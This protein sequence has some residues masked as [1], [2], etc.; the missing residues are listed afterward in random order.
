MHPSAFE[1]AR[2]FVEAYVVAG[3]DT[4]VEIGSQTVGGAGQRPIRPL[5]AGK[6]L[7][8][9]GVD[10]VAGEGV[11]VVLADPYSFPMPDDSADIVLSSSCFEHAQFFWLTF[12]E[13]VRICRPG[14]LL[15][16]SAPSNGGFHRYPVDCWRFYPDSGVALQD[17]ALRN[18]SRVTLLESYISKQMA[19][20]WNDFVAVWGKGE[21]AV[22]LHPSRILSGFQ[23][24]VNGRTAEN[25]EILNYVEMSE[26]MA[27]RQIAVQVCS[28][29]IGV[30]W[31]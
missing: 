1:S 15:Y 4:V 21:R 28:G 31:K 29:A 25:G 27:R 24:Y 20:G 10:F 6:A 2:R 7:N 3:V 30:N 5:F 26:D 23:N 22:H 12:L 14:G 13:M 18:G 17:W 19:D 9:V 16:V 11:D 8:Y